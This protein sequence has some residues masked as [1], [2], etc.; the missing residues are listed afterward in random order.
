MRKFM[1]L[2][3]WEGRRMLRFP[4]LEIFVVLVMLVV[5]TEMFYVSHRGS[6][7]G[8]SIMATTSAKIVMLYGVKITDIVRLS[9][10]NL[11]VIITLTGSTLIGNFMAKE[12]ENGSTKLFIS[13]PI[14][15]SHIFLSKYLVCLLALALVPFLA[16]IISA[17]ML[18]PRFPLHFLK[19]GREV[20]ALLILVFLTSF[21]VTSVSVACSVLSRNVAM[22]MLGAIG[23]LLVINIVSNDYTF[24]PGRS[25]SSVY[26]LLDGARVYSDTLKRAVA[27]LFMPL[28]G[29]ALSFVSYHVFTRRMELS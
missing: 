4:L 18:E 12:I 14:R 13:H 22:S 15:R 28:V 26:S 6:S 17:L 20:I 9:T 3:S 19:S 27:L 21:Y 8:A 23:I 16:I 29:M 24:L 7:G 10:S 2:F 1:K 5:V 11:F 25:L